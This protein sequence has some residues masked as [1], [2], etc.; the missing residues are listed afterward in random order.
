MCKFEV[1]V[2]IM[3][4]LCKKLHLNQKD[5]DDDTRVI[6]VE[7]G[8]DRLG[9]VV[10]NVSEVLRINKDSINKTFELMPLIHVKKELESISQFF[11][12]EIYKEKEATKKNFIKPF[13]I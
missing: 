3:N 2:M 6:V 11:K 13:I 1:E 7:T 4:P 5:D 9:I 8:N 12:P 10:D